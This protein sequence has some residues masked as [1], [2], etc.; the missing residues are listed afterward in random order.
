MY[1]EGNGNLSLNWL[2][3]T[4]K[5]IIIAIIIFLGC[6]IFIRV[7]SNGSA[8]SG[9][10]AASS[11]TEYITNIASMKSAAFE[12]FTTSKLPEKIGGTER[13]S[14]NQMIN[15][16]LLI[17]FTNNGKTCDTNSSYIQTTKTADGNYAL[18]V[19]L[20]CGSKSDF[21]V[22]T[23]E[24]TNCIVNNSCDNTERKTIVDDAD[25]IPTDDPKYQNAT[26]NET[27]VEETTNKTTNNTTTNNSTQ[28]VQPT[29][30]IVQPVYVPTTTTT[31]TTTI[32][33]TS[34][35]LKVSC[36]SCNTEKPK[37]EE[38]PIY[39]AVQ[40]LVKFDLN[41]G[42]GYIAS[43][44]IPAGHLAT[45]PTDPTRTGY[46][47]V[48][49]Q[50]NGMTYNFNNPV[51]KDIT[52]VA[53][54]KENTP[55][56]T[57]YYEYVRYTDWAEGYSYKTGAENK[58]FQVTKYNYCKNEQTKTYYSVG[59]V[60]DWTSTNTTYSYEYQMLDLD[61]N[62]VLGVAV[63][64]SSKS[65]FNNSNLRDYYNYATLKSSNSI[66]M[67]GNTGKYDMAISNPV[68]F[69]NSSLKSQHFTFNVSGAN[70]VSGT[71][72]VNITINYKNH[73]GLTPYSGTSNYPVPL[74]FDVNYYNLSDCITKSDNNFTYYK[75]LGYTTQI[76]AGTEYIWKHRE[77][78]RQMSPATSLYGW[79]R[80]GYYEDRI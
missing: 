70:L 48:E 60:S 54:W 71:Y 23:I 7:T 31:T 59:Y 8:K 65:Y 47:F 76:Y 57:R 9:S 52:L 43:Q 1:E 11:D 45:R 50:L 14:L 55:V 44:E 68:E 5:I 29:K 62:K 3:L 2:S 77:Q 24:K 75:N 39:P 16:K 58:Q 27:K 67:T 22:T 21:I 18:K 56:K 28:T 32:V 40:V 19:S 51:T 63:V 53:I 72:R 33:K 35:S 26:K 12:Y 25:V 42:S 37:E 36:S 20:D 17:D 30:I 66:Y 46:T 6:W 73:N 38:K 80:T 49:W 41:G 34:V 74:K 61:P 78:E 64:N 69:T 13:L 15:Q 4:V 10:L 79:T